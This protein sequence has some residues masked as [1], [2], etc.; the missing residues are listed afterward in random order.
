MPT[1]DTNHVDV[2]II[3]FCM[4]TTDVNQPPI[5][6]K[7]VN[8]YTIHYI[9]SGTGWVDFKGKRHNLTA[10]TLFVTF[11]NCD[12]V[13][14]Q[15][16]TDPW[17][18]GWIV[19]D[20]LKVKSLLERVGITKD[21]PLVSLAADKELRGLF[22]KTP[23]LCSKHRNMSDF[24]ALSAFYSILKCIMLQRPE[25]RDPDL[26]RPAEHHVALA[27]EYVNLHYTESDLSLKTVASAIGVSPN[28]LSAIFKSVSAVSFSRHLLNKRL[29]A[30][31][32]L[33][34]EGNTVVSDVAYK[35]GFSSPYYFSNQFR[36]YNNDSPKQHIIKVMQKNKEDQIKTN[37]K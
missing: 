5:Q 28:Y 9:L 32:T 11:P 22:S 24:I 10:D 36:K 19:L 6:A 27:M 3:G 14:S 21:K 26:N 7:T 4:E 13:H 31:L 17:T 34:K 8:Q 37:E 16:L 23:Y 18:L 35:V 29:S 20:G 25:S 1:L 12:I 33:I 30:A 15:D 2:H